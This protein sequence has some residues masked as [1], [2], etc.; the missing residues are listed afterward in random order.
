MKESSVRETAANI[1]KLKKRATW[2]TIYSDY[3]PDPLDP[4]NFLLVQVCG[5]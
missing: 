5:I 1:V 2:E 4:G 3:N